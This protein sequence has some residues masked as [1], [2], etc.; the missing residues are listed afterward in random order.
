[1]PIRIN[2]Q[3]VTSFAEEKIGNRRDICEDLKL[4]ALVYKS[5]G[6]SISISSGG[7]DF[8]TR[9]LSSITQALSASARLLS[10]E[11][12][13]ALSVSSISA[14]EKFAILHFVSAQRAFL[15]GVETLL[16]NREGSGKDENKRQ[17]AERSKASRERKDVIERAAEIV[18][19]IDLPYMMTEHPSSQIATYFKDYEELISCLV[20]PTEVASLDREPLKRCIE[21]SMHE[22]SAWISG[23]TEAATAVRSFLNYEQQQAIKNSVIDH[24]NGLTLALKNWLPTNG[25]EEKRKEKWQAY[26]KTLSSL[27]DDRA[28][29]FDEAFGVRN[30]FVQPTATYRVAGVKRSKP[31]PVADVAGLLGTLLS[32]RTPADDLILLCGGPGSGKS[33]LC[34]VLASEL[35]ENDQIHPV[36]LRLRRLTDTQD[37]ASFIEGHLQNEGLIDKFSDLGGVPN[38]VLILDGFD[39]LVM[40]SRSKLREFFNALKDDLS[41]GPLRDAK[42]IVSGRDTLFPNG[43]GLPIGA[44]VVSLEPFDRQRV[45]KWGSKWRALHKGRE[46]DNFFPEKLLSDGK[47]KGRNRSPLEH[48]VS[49]PLT[50]HLVARAHTSG[51]I[52]LKPDNAKLVEKAVLYRS[53]VADTALRQENQASGHGRLNPEQ[54]RQFVQ[55]IAWEMYSSGREA[56]DV[57]E[58][59]PILRS[60]LP[61]ATDADLAELADV[62]IVNQPELTKGEETGF[63]FVHKSFS[64]YFAAEV[65]ATSLEKA[66]FQ[67]QQWGSK[68][69]TWAM[70]VHDATQSLGSLFSMR[71]FTAEVQEMLE[72]ML[73]DF[74]SF[75]DGDSAQLTE[76][77][78][79][80]LLVNLEIKL[81]RLEELLVDFS[82]GN[83]L[84]VI[85]QITKLRRP[86]LSPLESFG[87]YASAL[88]FV[89]VA[90]ANRIGRLDRKKNRSVSI[91]AQALVRLIHMILSGEIQIDATFSERGLT[92]IDTASVGQEKVDIIFP[93]IAPALLQGVSGL[94]I[95]LSDAVERLGA[96]L[97]T[98]QLENV[99]LSL[100]LEASGSKFDG[101]RH[102]RR[103]QSDFWR[104][105][106]RSSIDH[107][108]R[109]FGTGSFPGAAEELHFFERRVFEVLERF[110]SASNIA[111]SRR[112][113]DEILY[114]IRDV[115]SD[116]YRGG[117]RFREIEDRFRML[118]EHM[119]DDVGEPARRPKAPRQE[120]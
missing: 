36:F 55:A 35:A 102:H 89:S 52:D 103:F 93:P 28:T 68:E 66:C 95:P 116:G 74:K 88:L 109:S 21:L 104:Y 87:N 42:A 26:R 2:I 53:I 106:S 115:L 94:A 110:R 15:K 39:E 83:Y 30:V 19:G 6:N 31:V 59:L 17:P 64:E 3:F 61:A 107:L 92:R 85:A 57:N 79:S 112:K 41:S 45:E 40:A 14:L 105:E 69:E 117:Y 49:W 54:M 23:D 80:K 86:R 70:S 90:L 84:D 46:V 9:V 27:P 7:D 120:N 73:G 18:A 34:R 58:G 50:L 62:T 12:V 78:S 76:T 13:S 75:L 1:M 71:L 16:N 44:H 51:S 25:A 33:T 43:A 10:A 77:P 108:Q 113:L 101:L 63:E 72:P 98:T 48:L 111:I 38:L 99:L 22:Y 20:D 96:A 118:L 29:M 91:P 67:T 114:R 97:R 32:A 56:L 24:V 65:I 119:L 4:L 60:I 5:I 11:T 82:G 81:K 37:V 100:M 8:R 47:A